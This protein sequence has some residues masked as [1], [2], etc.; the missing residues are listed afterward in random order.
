MTNQEVQ[1]VFL[2]LIILALYLL[3]NT[4]PAFKKIWY[5]VR[6]FFIVLLLTL[7][8]NYAK[9]KIKDWWSK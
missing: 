1:S 6:M 7:G 3:R 2:W 4:N 9:D 5:F 8:A